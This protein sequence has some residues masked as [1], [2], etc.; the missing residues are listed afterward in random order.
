MENTMEWVPVKERLPELDEDGYSDYVLVSFA[1]YVI[2]VIGQYADGDWH[3]GDDEKTLGKYGLKVNAWMPLP[4]C[5]E[6]G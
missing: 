6:E 2:P 3:D 1:N 5:Y 4:K